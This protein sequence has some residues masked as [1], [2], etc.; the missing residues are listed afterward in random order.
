MY[1]PLLQNIQTHIYEHIINGGHQTMTLDV[2]AMES[3]ICIKNILSHHFEK[4]KYKMLYI[5]V[6][7][8]ES[9]SEKNSTLYE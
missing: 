2:K 4:N 8:L 5:Y 9:G 6:Y 3:Y 7:K 1:G